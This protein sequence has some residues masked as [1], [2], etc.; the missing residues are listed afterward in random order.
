MWTLRSCCPR[1]T[2]ADASSRLLRDRVES[3]PLTCSTPSICSASCSTLA[4]S[5]VRFIPPI[6]R[7]SPLRQLAVHAQRRTPHR[8]IHD[9]FRTDCF[10]R[11]CHCPERRLQPL[12]RWKSRLQS[13]I[14]VDARP[15]PHRVRSTSRS[16]PISGNGRSG[17]R[18]LPSAFRPAA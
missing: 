4:S 18:S 17:S 12:R 2:P 8:S 13:G 10:A 6:Q 7:E 15:R 16:G 11:R 5:V 9:Q 1:R 14:H 3:I